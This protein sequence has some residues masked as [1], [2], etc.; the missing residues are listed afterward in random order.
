MCDFKEICSEKGFWNHLGHHIKQ[1]ETVPCPILRCNFKTNTRSTFSSHRSRNHKNC[2]LRDFRSIARADTED[3]GND[4]EQSDGET[5]TALH[6]SVRPTEVE[7]FPED[8]DSETRQHKLAS[9]FLCIQTLLHVSRSSTQ[10]IVEDLHNLL[11]FSNIHTLNS[12]K[13]PFEA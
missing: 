1:R 10:K 12:V 7:E 8:V 4:G 5:G 3:V 6:N 13:D 11:S 9:L 2:T